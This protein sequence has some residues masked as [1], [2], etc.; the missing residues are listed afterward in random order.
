[1]S[2]H[3]RFSILRLALFLQLTGCT[4]YSLETG[5]GRLEVDEGGDP[6]E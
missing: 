2:R 5:D 4:D 1:M 6:H 3:M